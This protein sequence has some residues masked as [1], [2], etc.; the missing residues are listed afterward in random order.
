VARSS[1]PSANLVSQA[2]VSI[3][4]AAPPA[5]VLRAFFDRA[6]L[7]AWWQALASVTTPRPFGP[8]VVEWRTTDFRDEVLGRLGGVLRGTVIQ[9]DPAEGFFLA[10]VYWLP[11][12]GDPIGPM[13][14]AV[15]IS[16]APPDP[17]H[18][19]SGELTQLRI[20]QT[21]FEDSPRWR[22]YY[23]VF[24]AGWERAAQTLKGLLER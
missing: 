23:A 12:D 1:T 16:T 3:V 8:Y 11:P 10:D 15:T 7:S 19:V 17:E 2:D 20:H 14:I 21:G 18:P 9:I 22:R 13:A 5:R 24:G 6:A 4:I